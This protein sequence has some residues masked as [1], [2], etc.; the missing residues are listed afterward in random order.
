[1]LRDE[2]T[3]SEASELARYVP[4]E[5]CRRKNRPAPAAYQR[6]DNEKY[7]SV[8]STEVETTNQIAEIYATKFESDT[9]PVAIE[10]A[11]AVSLI[12]V[13]GSFS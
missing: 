6:K 11:I 3:F 12:H 7:L 2:P 9:R 8:N 5:W 13:I 10:A 4:P 1:M